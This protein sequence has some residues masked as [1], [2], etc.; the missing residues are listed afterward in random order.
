MGVIL[1]GYFIFYQPDSSQFS[2]IDRY[3]KTAQRVGLPLSQRKKALS[4]ATSY[5]QGLP[6]S[7]ERQKKLSELAYLAYRLRDST[8]FYNNNRLALKEAQVQEDV[9]AIADAHWNFGAFALQK[10]DFDKAYFHYAKARQGFAKVKHRYY[11]A[12]MNYNLAFIKARLKEY[13]ASEALLYKALPVF[14]KKKRNKQIYLCYTQLGL[15]YE[16]LEGFAVAEKY[17]RKALNYLPEEQQFLQQ[18]TYNNLGLLALKRGGY[19]SAIAYYNKALENTA[20]EHDS[21]ALY[22]RL[23]DN[24]AYAKFRCFG[25]P[26]LQKEFKQ[27]LSIRDSL[28]NKEGIVINR[29]HLAEFYWAA[30]DTLKAIKQAQQAYQLAH[31]IQLKRDELKAL[32]LLATIDPANAALYINKW[33]KVQHQHEQQLREQRNKVAKIQY[34]TQKFKKQS[35]RLKNQQT[36]LFISLGVLLLLIGMLFFFFKQRTKL[37]RLAIQRA[38]QKQLEEEREE[39]RYRIAEDLHDGVLSKLFGLRMNWAMLPLKGATSEIQQHKK[40]LITLKSM[41]KEIR[42]I[43]H[44]LKSEHPSANFPFMK[45]LNKLISEKAELGGFTYELQIENSVQEKKIAQE[46]ST[47]LYS[48]LEET[49][50]NIIKHAQASEVRLRL[51]R[52]SRSLNLMIADNG[53]GF[54]VKSNEQGIGLMNIKRRV[55]KLEGKVHFRSQPGKGTCVFIRLIM[56]KD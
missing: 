43:S 42:D 25:T 14:L 12:K 15:I 48:V 20:I 9:F 27:A 56:G 4:Q 33:Y 32:E 46:I 39:E 36:Y 29:I 52:S 7:S 53:C 17:H 50:Y 16:E 24:R 3:I 26:G 5:I 45:N 6:S 54:R 19:P 11:E 40:Y 28:Q 49:L 34:E 41:E 38:Q 1:G 10:G 31:S 21:P 2:P 18:A 55:Q 13:E 22:A 51:R 47:S 30:Q 23:L 8:N 37:K 44:N 35:I